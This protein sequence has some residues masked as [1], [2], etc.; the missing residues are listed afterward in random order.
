ME[1]VLE[2]LIGALLAIVVLIVGAHFLLP[3]MAES[4][5]FLTFAIPPTVKWGMSGLL[6]L[7]GLLLGLFGSAIAMGRYL[8]A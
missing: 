5:S 8:K 6:L 3:V 4:M 1:G 2:A 7:L